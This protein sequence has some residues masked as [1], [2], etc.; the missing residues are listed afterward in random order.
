MSREAVNQ[1]IDR[2]VADDGFFEL[3]RNNPEQ[4]VQG[5][6]LDASEASA[7]K[8]G[9]YNVVVRA[10]RVDHADEAALQAK[11]VTAA[12]AARQAPA[13]ADTTL[14]RPPRAPVGGLIGF[15]IGIIVI[16]GGLGAFRY[17]EHQWPWQMAGFGKAAAPAAIP[18][19]SLGARPK[20]LGQPASA[21]AVA[22][23]P[24]A[25]G[26]APAAAPKPQASASGS[27]GQA[28]LRPSPSPS[29]SASSASAAQQSDTQKAY[30]Q[31]V[32]TRM[33][34]LLR[35]FAATLADI[36]SG[37]DPS[38]NLGD[39]SSATS[40]LRQHLGDAPPP[41]QLKQ[42]HQTLVQAVPLFQS[43]LD[44][45]KSAIEQKNTIQVIL[46]TAEM[47]ALLDQVPDEVAFANAAHPEMYQPIDSSQQL[48]H[49]QNF[50]V[51][52]QNVTSRNSAAATVSL[53]IGLQSQNPTNDEVSDTLR[54]SVVAARQSFPQ[55]GQIRV[56]AFK[57]SN[58]SVGNQLGAADWY[59]SP[60]ARPPDAAA[61]GNW[62]DYC[63][64]IYL[65][66]P[67]SGGNNVTAVPY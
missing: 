49:I 22:A 25:G 56:M 60:E 27:S 40:D 15:F 62:Q 66:L 42:Q 30:F 44:Q 59:C 65:S 20:P 2:A 6:E 10:K 26:P 29:A 14:Q 36:R 64:K 43:G 45:L 32:G 12:N 5:Y 35:A 37:N 53:R 1:I 33:G 9:A 58:G 63:G 50:D 7:V 41:D 23:K 3:L 52:S 67:A 46:V 8:S 13:L 47:R 55:A 18:A 51:I 21:S 39:L 19:P 54:H 24:S 11:R 34:T 28:T 57:E 17:F 4:A 61:G 48:S 31:S 38:K 16:G